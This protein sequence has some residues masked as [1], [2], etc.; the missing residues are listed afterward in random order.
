MTN[1]EIPGNTIGFPG[2]S[3]GHI[4]NF[5]AFPGPA[6]MKHSGNVVFGIHT[7][8]ICKCNISSNNKLLGHVHTV[9][10]FMTIREIPENAGKYYRIF[11]YFPG[12][13]MEFPGVSRPRHTDT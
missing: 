2:I 4:W 6:I 5:P 10:V 12:T 9:W 8:S 7:Y 3:P 13:Y 1:R 11:R